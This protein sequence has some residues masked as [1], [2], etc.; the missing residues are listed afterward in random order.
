MC[1]PW[2][3]KWKT[4]QLEALREEWSPCVQ[5]PELV[6]H[7]SKVVMGFGNP[8][9]DIMLIGA[10]PGEVEDEEGKP[11]RGPSGDFLRA[12]FKALQYPM[13]ELFLSNVLACR[14]PENREGATDEK[15][16]CRSRLLEEVY[17][18]DPKIIILVG[19]EAMIAMLRG[20]ETSIEKERGR[21][22]TLTVIGKRFELRYD[23][24]PIFHPS[25]ILRNER[26]EKD[27]KYADDSDAMRTYRDIEQAVRI[28]GHINGAYRRYEEEF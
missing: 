5:C 13:R 6:A 2:T 16:S 15:K 17:I 7:R 10:S 11:F 14:P 19:R 25:H 4:Q 28:V 26:P 12:T 3:R 18:V 20:R 9:A 8:M 24:I 1:K 23:C 27:G 22:K 21:M